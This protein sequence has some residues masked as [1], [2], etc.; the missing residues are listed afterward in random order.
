MKTKLNIIQIVPFASKIS[1]IISIVISAVVIFAQ[2]THEGIVF[3]FQL[4][5]LSFLALFLGFIIVYPIIFFL[6]YIIISIFNRIFLKNL[7]N[8][9]KII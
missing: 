1:V 9:S 5:P 7:N 6:T 2:G 8:F 4:S 3:N